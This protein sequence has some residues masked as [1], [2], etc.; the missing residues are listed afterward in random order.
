MKLENRVALVTG[1]GA[2]IGQAI[3]VRFAQEGA[4]IMVADCNRSSYASGE[5]TV[6]TIK[7]SGGNAA[8]VL[9]DVSRATD[10]EKMVRETVKAFGRLD[11]L[12]NNAGIELY[13]TITEM[14]EEEWDTLIDINLKGVFLCSKYAIPEMA[15]GGVIINMSSVAGFRGSPRQSAYCASKGGVM[16]MTQALAAELRPQGIRVNALNPSIID[17]GMG[18]F[19]MDEINAVVGA[20][21]PS[22]TERIEQRQG[23][24]GTPEDVANAALFLASDEASFITGHGLSVD[25]G[26]AAM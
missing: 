26:S 9:A 14:T 25:G 23:R 6:E 17:D 8:F 4:S 2:G 11:I 18:R 24:L 19:L 10:A 15:N 1:A 5:G 21:I 16:L 3:A 7:G 20:G 12:V 22:L 13:R